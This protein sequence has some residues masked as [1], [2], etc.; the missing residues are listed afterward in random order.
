MKSGQRTRLHRLPERGAYDLE[1]VHSILDAG[2]LAHVGFSVDSQVVVIP[3]LYARSG[4]ALYLHGSADSRTLRV[5]ATGSAAC[6]TVT[7][8]DG[9]VLARSA[10]HHSMNYRSVV[11]F[12][13]ARSVVSAAQR[14]KAL[15]AISEHIVPGRWNEVRGPSRTELE[16][17]AVL[18]FTIEEAS[19]KIRKGPPLDEEEDYQR[20][21]WAGV[22]PLRM[23]TGEPLPDP[24][25]DAAIAAPQYL[26]RL[27]IGR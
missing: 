10:F 14:V 26:S 6:V 9:L 12:G 1:T 2:F 21:V 25:L 13:T 27:K 22:L 8:V 18:K 5:L 11:A 19:A 24:R 3:T 20:R 23:E 7:L 15:H 16:V 17:T 4:H